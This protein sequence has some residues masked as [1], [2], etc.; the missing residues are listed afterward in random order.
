MKPEIEQFVDKA[1]S[2]GLTDDEI[3]QKLLTAGWPANEVEDAINGLTAPVPKASDQLDVPRP[4]TS[5]SAIQTASPQPVTVVQNQSTRGLE[6]NIM[7]LALLFTAFG[8][9]GMLHDVVDSLTNT[10]TYAHIGG[11]FAVTAF[12]VLGPIFTLLFLRLK[13]AEDSE[14]ELHKDPFRKRWIQWTLLF[15]FLIGIGHIIYFVYSILNPSTGV[16]YYGAASNAPAGNETLA[17]VLHVLVTL[18]IAGGIFAYYW[19]EE[20]KPTDGPNT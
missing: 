20:H 2:K 14:P 5:T 3:R 16:D 13:K 12:L 8:L 10:S 1:R 11:A 15:S 4:S 17:L 18:A 19:I 6:Y 9:G 7:F